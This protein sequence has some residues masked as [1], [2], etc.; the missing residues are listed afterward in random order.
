[1]HGMH[2]RLP[3]NFVLEERLERYGQV[4]ELDP[5]LWRGRWGEA[6]AP[7]GARSFSEV[8]L[9]LGCG[10]GAFAI[11]A[12]RREPDVLFVAMDSEPVCVAYAAQHV[13]ESGLPNVVVVPGNGMRVREFFSPGE[14]SRIY[15][16]FPTPFPRKRDAGKRMACMERLLDFRDVLSAGAEV[17]LRTDS[18]PLFDFM[19][20][21]VPLAGYDLL[22]TSRDARADF[23]DE[24]S[25]EYEER[26]GAQG[27]CVYALAATPGEL[28]EHIEQTAELSLAEYLPHDLAELES[29]GYAPHGMQATVVNLRNRASRKAAREATS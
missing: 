27:A 20:T 1:M 8:R 26:L 29:L 14:L 10:K 5:A 11:E 3:K 23:P 9:D 18:Q 24:P 22:W 28:P 16:N 25:S 21:Q 12:A 13:C 7:L 19:L 17:R 15:L 2:A 4:I 6:C